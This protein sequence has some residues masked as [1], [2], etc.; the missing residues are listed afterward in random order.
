MRV[1]LLIGYVGK[2]QMLLDLDVEHLRKHRDRP[3]Y[4]LILIVELT[5]A[6]ARLTDKE[7]EE[8]AIALGVEWN[9]SMIRLKYKFG[10]AGAYIVR[11]GQIREKLMAEYKNVCWQVSQENSL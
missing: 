8:L 11:L 9:L 7:Q 10:H 5:N 6:I 4:P 3:E 2:F 1:K